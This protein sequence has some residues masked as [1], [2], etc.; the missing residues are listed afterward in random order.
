[1]TEHSCVTRPCDV[2]TMQYIAGFMDGDGSIRLP[3]PSAE[4]SRATPNIVISQSRDQGMPPEF[5]PFLENFGGNV[6]TRKLPPGRRKGWVWRAKSVDVVRKILGVIRD[7]SITKAPQAERA[8]KYLDG[9]RDDC[10][11]AASFLADSKKSYHLVSI[12][13]NRVSFPYIAGLFAADGSVSLKRQKGSLRLVT[14]ITQKSCVPLLE[15]IKEKLGGGCVDKERIYLGSAVGV[16][17]LEKMR[18]YLEHSQK[19]EQVD[20]AIEFH[21]RARNRTRAEAKEQGNKDNE[22]LAKMKVLKRG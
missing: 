11:A 9:R 13:T 1:M 17:L 8:L 19:R 12:P 15:A 18:P 7:N 5:V 16:R 21:S 10:E 4:R 22:I 6:C 2:C 3:M 14:S 20:L